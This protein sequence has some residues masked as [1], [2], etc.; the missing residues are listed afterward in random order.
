MPLAYTPESAYAKER[1]KWESQHTSLGPPGRPY[2]Y[3]EYP[4]RLYKAGRINGITPGI[5]EAINVESE[6]EERNMRSRGFC[7][8]QDKAIEAFHASEQALAEGAANRAFHDRRLSAP[9]QREA[10]AADA[11]SP[12]H[13]AEVPEKPRRGRKPKPI[14]VPHG[15]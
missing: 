4:K 8:G 11:A 5:V 1:V 12:H 10:A 15:V 3:Q 9:A 14:E 13:V 2:E 7:V 6:V